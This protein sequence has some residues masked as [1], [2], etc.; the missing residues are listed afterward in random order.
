MSVKIP[1]ALTCP[2]PKTDYDTIQMAHGAGGRL[3]AELVEKF[4]LPRF[5]N[6]ILEKL[7]D[8]A[9]I[10]L[11]PGRVA[12]STDSFVVSPIFFPGGDIG[13][14]AVNGTV[15]DVAMSG[16]KPRY[17]TAGFILE[18]GLPLEVL[19][20]V[21]LSMEAAASRAGV[22]IITGD[23]KVVERGH[24]DNLFINTTGIGVI[25]TH[26][27][28]SAGNLKP[29]DKILLSGTIA[30][31]G[32]AILT[33]RKGLSFSSELTSDT[34]PLNG[35]VEAMTTICPEIHALRDPTRGGVAMTL[36][37]FARASH[38]GILIHEERIPI[39]SGVRGAC[40]ILGLDPLLVANEGKL[41]ASVPPEAADEV[42][43]AMRQ[44]PLGRN[45]VEL[46]EVTAENTGLVVMRTA[47]GTH[48]IVDVPLGEQLPRIC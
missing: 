1:E 5:R 22:N 7:D 32:A 13:D 2:I 10:D 21:L 24:C 20:R 4:F 17:L 11:P 40:E 39:Q 44:H 33:T 12:I 47:L 14:L 25:A 18:E 29:G 43:A 30:D 3:S 37:E 45:A 41:I 19:H 16:A 42:L 9:V 38:V 23:T 36:N 48:R 28:I 34:A 46:G 26:L 15:N 6:A 8:Q 27:N 35:L 31:H